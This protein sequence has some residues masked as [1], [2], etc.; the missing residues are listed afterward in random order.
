MTEEGGIVTFA[1][2]MS[3]AEADP[4]PAGRPS[5]FLSYAS[6][7]RPAV[8]R[9][10]DALEA[11]GVDAWYDENELTGGDAWDTKIRRQIREC[12]YFMPVISARASARLEG[13][14]RREWR[15][16]LE[17]MLDMADDVVFLLPV[18]I[19][20]S[21]ES[22]ARVPEKFVA[23]QWLRV[24]EG[25]ATKAFN[26]LA[27]RLAAGGAERL[28]HSPAARPAER[29]GG[30]R[31]PQYLPPLDS[32]PP[33]G[34][35]AKLKYY[36]K[37]LPRWARILCWCALIIV[38]LD[39]C[40]NC[41]GSKPSAPAARKPARGA[42]TEQQVQA[43]TNVAQD[44]AAALRSAGIAA[45]PRRTTDI[46][47]LAASAKGG[48]NGVMSDI[49]GKLVTSSGVKSK[50]NVTALPEGETPAARAQA[51]NA[52]FALLCEPAQSP[53]G[54]NLIRVTLVRAADGAAV[55]TADYAGD[56]SAGVIS[57]QAFAQILPVLLKKD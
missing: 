28:H 44:V 40:S 9:L 11:A 16:A 54:K 17:R 14:F 5:V 4:R 35:G 21:Q 13:Y 55:W 34:I 48:A 51:E 39:S 50:F 37:K 29:S 22:T 53:E 32:G 31:A 15:F 46:I 12:T 18:V 57:A 45:A 3:S 38:A 41:R 7:D 30:T 24:P 6:E 43:A 49:Y 23:V 8:R 33:E 19:D 42:P 2:A 56:E 47:L 20:D 1:P 26:D 27:R 10:R 25:N 52:R 36:W